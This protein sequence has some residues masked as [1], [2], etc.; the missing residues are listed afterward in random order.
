MKIFRT[1]L[2]ALATGAV[3]GAASADV[4]VVQSVQIDSPQLK[5]MMQSLGP[6]QRARLA[7]FGLGGTITSKSY[8]KGGKSRT[9]VGQVTSVIVDSAAGRMT[10]VNRVS[11]TFSTQP[12]SANAARGMK[13]S[14][15]ATGKTKVI[16]GHLCRDYRLN[17]TGASASGPTTIAGDI[18]A[19]PDLPR[20]PAQA[21]GGNGPT[22]AIASQWAKIAGMPLQVVMTI[23]GSPLGKT[24]VRSTVRSVSTKP[25]SPSVFAIPVGYRPGPAGMMMPGMGGMGQ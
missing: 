24:T 9:D 1:I 23:N 8:V 21:L 5:A 18:W 20:L 15:K 3:A 13:S 16:L 12:I 25:V 7:Q 6:E 10:T 2:L 22:A 17:M 11:H 19:A 14:L 4:T